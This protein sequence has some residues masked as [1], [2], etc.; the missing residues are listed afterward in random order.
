MSELYRVAG[1][2][3]KDVMVCL[4]PA[5]AIPISHFGLV[6]RLV[7]ALPRIDTLKQSSCI[8]GAWMA[9]A[10]VKVQ[11]AKMKATEIAIAGAT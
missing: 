4:W 3:M 9:F 8:E 1:L 10:R 7:D 5:E 11:W 6:K 2:A